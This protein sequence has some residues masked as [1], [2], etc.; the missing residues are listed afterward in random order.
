MVFQQ[1]RNLLNVT[2]Y[3][4][5]PFECQQLLP[6]LSAATHSQLNPRQTLG[7]GFI[8]HRN[9]LVKINHFAIPAVILPHQNLLD[10][11][12]LHLEIHHRNT[13]FVVHVLI[14]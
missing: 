1:E 14:V 12:H 9:P 7:N 13:G 5:A 4:T 8:Q 11:S 6:A 2:D 10:H 3:Q